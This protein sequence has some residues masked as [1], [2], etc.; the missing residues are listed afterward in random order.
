MSGRLKITVML[1]GPSAE[2]EISLRSG[3]AVVKALRGLGH[4]VSELDPRQPDWTLPE[5]T[6]LVFLTL[7]GTYGEDGQVQQ[8]LED[9]AVPYTGCGPEASRRA[10]DKLSTKEACV[11][12]GLSTPRY[13][14]FDAPAPW[15]RGWRPPVVLKPVRQ[16]SSVGLQF[17]ERV[18][19]WASA[20]TEA[21]RYD[22]RVVMEEKIHGREVTVALL[23]GR[24]LPVVEIRPKTGGFDYRNK[25]T[26]GTTD[27][28]CPAPFEGPTTTRIQ[29][30][31]LEA[32]RAVGGRD[33]G[34]VDIMVTREG[35]PMVLEVNSLPGMTDSSLLPKAAAA[36]GLTFPELCQRMVEL[37][38]QRS[39]ALAH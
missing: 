3:A 26:T 19:D 34:R 1:G 4:Q 29:Q 37:A 9:L 20:L 32:F 14:V 17:V 5:G 10:F 31:A 39:H 30:A 27:Y 38:W 12:A 36:A 25:Y 28:F 8:R 15:P 18:S 7:H 23:A 35:E 33:F 16:G 21:F 13:L 22:S 24:A 11:D 2:R 6:E